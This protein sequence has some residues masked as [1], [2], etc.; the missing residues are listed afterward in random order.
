MLTYLVLLLSCFFSGV[1][2]NP[3]ERY[4]PSAAHGHAVAEQPSGAV[5]APALPHARRLQPR[6]RRE[7][8]YVII[9]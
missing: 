5:G 9:D 7:V 2:F 6:H 1:F 3:G 4:L 8:C